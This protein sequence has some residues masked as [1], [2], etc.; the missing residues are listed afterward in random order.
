MPRRLWLSAGLLA[1]GAGPLATARL[2]GAAPQSGGIFRVGIVGA[3]VQVDPQ[4]SGG[5]LYTAMGTRGSDLDLGASMGFCSDSGSYGVLKGFVAAG[6][7]YSRKLDAARS[8]PKAL[9]KLDLEITR[10][11]APAV[12]MRTYNNRFFFSGRVDPRSL[13]FNRVYGDWSI[14]ALSLS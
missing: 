13:K 5:D 2:A 4:V 14:P 6:S 9:G 10:A 11:L 7:K 12:A 3:S 1:A 8:R